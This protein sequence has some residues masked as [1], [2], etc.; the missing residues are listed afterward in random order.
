MS[1]QQE[2]QKRRRAE[3]NC[4][5]CGEKRKPGN[6]NHCKAHA[7]VAAINENLRYHRRKKVKSLLDTSK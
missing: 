7:R 5:A 3:G 4:I 6:K 1:R 2:Y